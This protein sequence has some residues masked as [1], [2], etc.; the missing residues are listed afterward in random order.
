MGVLLILFS[1]PSLYGFISLVFAD[2]TDQ[3][4]DFWEGNSGCISFARHSGIRAV[5]RRAIDS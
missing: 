5:S 4:M 3:Y 1:C 2:R